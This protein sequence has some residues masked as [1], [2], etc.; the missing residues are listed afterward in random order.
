[1]WSNKPY[2]EISLLPEIFPISSLDLQP[3]R[4]IPRGFPALANAVKEAKIVSPGG[5]RCPHYF[6]II[7]QLPL[8]SL[9]CDRFLNRFAGRFSYSFLFVFAA[10]WEKSEVSW[11]RQSSWQPLFLGV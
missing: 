8:N 4:P 1:M 7:Q 5:Y 6:D 11:T 9:I 10:L 2:L 3:G